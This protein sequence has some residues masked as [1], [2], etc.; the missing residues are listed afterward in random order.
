MHDT[1]LHAAF[2]LAADEITIITVSGN[3][4]TA[5]LGVNSLGPSDAY[6]RQ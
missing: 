1:V 3:R 5:S 2:T 6:M 4:V